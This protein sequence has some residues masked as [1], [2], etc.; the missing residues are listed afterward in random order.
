MSKVRIVGGGLT[1]I[2]AAFEAH[3]LGARDIELH[4]RFDRLG[5]VALPREAHGLELREGCIYFG[6]KG[7]PIRDLL[8]W[9]GLAFE[10]FENRF[11]SV[12]PGPGASLRF[13]EDFGGP[14]I[15]CEEIAL[16]PPTG[17]SLADR[18]RAYPPQVETA[19]A[20]YCRWHL[21]TWLDE[22]HES[23]AIPL[24][25]NRVYP[26]GADLTGLAEAK[27]RSPL[28]DE[29]YAIPRGL[30]GRTNN[31]TAA[32]PRDGFPVLFQDCRRVLERLGVKIHERA[33][34]SPRQAVAA[35]APGEVLVWAANPTPL[36]KVMDVPTPKLLPKSFAI[37]HFK[38]RW[39][40][41]KPFYVQNFTAQGAVFRA[42]VY[43]SRGETLVT[44][45]CVGETP[46]ADLRAELVRLAAG[47]GQLEVGEAL[48]SSVQAR[49]IYHSMDAMRRLKALHAALERQMGA[50]FVA[51]AWEPYAK[52]EKFQIVSESLAKALAA[53]AGGAVAAA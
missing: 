47:F 4:E 17:I 23:A 1:G 31:L 28:C 41:P 15:A 32:L 24:A 50:S 8:E 38:A 26:V 14:A 36:F 29:L 11:G 43:E 6:P 21:G 12:S 37:Y 25:I 9:H 18:L 13:T 2:L 42:Y 22:V 49:W 30:W 52:G 48:G 51:G 44:A 7:D 53:E 45:E 35:H 16:T 5:G 3:R 20:R 46:D 19:L 10:D 40:G 34:V 39:T 33:L 27:R